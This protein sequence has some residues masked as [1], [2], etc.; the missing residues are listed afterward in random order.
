MAKRSS[1]TTTTS[2]TVTKEGGV[3]VTR[4]ETVTRTPL[5][6]SAT[7]GAVKPARSPS[8]TKRGG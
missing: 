2:R 1:S 4:T 7:G 8:G 3:R 5:P 6:P